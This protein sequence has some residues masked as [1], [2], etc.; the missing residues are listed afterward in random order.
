MI[1]VMVVVGNKALDGLCQI[2]LAIIDWDNDAY[3]PIAG[4]AG[5]HGHGEA[6][7]ALR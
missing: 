1:Y 3:K 5:F 6:C 4:I 7:F 2:T